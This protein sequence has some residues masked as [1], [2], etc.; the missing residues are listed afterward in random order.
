M[1]MASL[2][3]VMVRGRPNEVIHQDGTHAST[4]TVPD[5]ASSL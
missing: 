4:G 2:P 5:D 3:M 1:I